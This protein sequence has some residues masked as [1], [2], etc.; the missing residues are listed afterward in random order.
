MATN[1]MEIKQR[2]ENFFGYTRHSI[3]QLDEE[4][5]MVS[6]MYNISEMYRQKHLVNQI[7]IKTKHCL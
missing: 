2:T 6:Y 1:G 4:T 5:S 3:V 7:Y